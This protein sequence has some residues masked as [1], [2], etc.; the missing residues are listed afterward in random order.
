MDSR[1]GIPG[2]NPSRWWSRGSAWHGTT[3]PRGGQHRRG[4]H[5]RALAIRTAL[6]NGYDPVTLADARDPHPCPTLFGLTDLIP[7]RP[8]R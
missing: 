7:R 3:W 1:R 6:A 2:L 5:T 8:H 4:R